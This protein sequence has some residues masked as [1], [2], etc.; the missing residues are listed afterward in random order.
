MDTELLN[1]L[2]RILLWIN[3]LGKQVYCH[4]IYMVSREGLV[5]SHLLE[6]KTTGFESSS[7]ESENSDPQRHPRADSPACANTGF[8]PLGVLCLTALTV[9]SAPNKLSCSSL[10][11]TSNSALISQFLL[12][13]SMSRFT[14]IKFKQRTGVTLKKRP[15]ESHSGGDWEKRGWGHPTAAADSPPGSSRA[16]TSWGDRP[17]WLMLPAHCI[18]EGF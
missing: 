12:D 18:R 6:G 7:W 15:R 4:L 9:P 10:S 8:W 1:V 3:F 13:K 2:K 5:L 11:T 17:A 16:R 14:E